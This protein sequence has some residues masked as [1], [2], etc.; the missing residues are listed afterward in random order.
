MTRSLQVAAVVV[1]MAGPA[2]AQDISSVVVEGVVSSPLETVWAAWTTSE[3]LRSWYA[4]HAEIDL[5]IGGLMRANYDA[6]GA[7]GDS[8]T[9]EERGFVHSNPTR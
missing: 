5:R 7:L 3:G 4:P 8:Q 2:T 6:Q 9:V 1:I